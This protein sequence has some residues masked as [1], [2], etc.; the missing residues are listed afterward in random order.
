M[1]SSLYRDF[2]NKTKHWCYL[3]FFKNIKTINATLAFTERGV[4]YETLIQL[5]NVKCKLLKKYK[6][7]DLFGIGHQ[8]LIQLLNKNT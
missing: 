7:K 6:T 3:T 4:G 2:F 1:T 5:L 8:T